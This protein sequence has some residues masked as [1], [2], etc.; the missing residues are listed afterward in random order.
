MYGN[1]IRAFRILR[2][3]SQEYMAE[4]LGINQNTYSRIETNKHKVSV[5]QVETIAKEL[6]V[7][8]V[9]I[10]SNEPLIIQN[11]ASNYGAQG[12][13]EHFY[14]DQKDLYEKLIS[15]KDEEIKNLREI[16][17]SLKEVI[18]SLKK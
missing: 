12:Q 11:I 5:E 16:I 15:S 17:Q 8:I 18:E 2:G 14:A 7:S 4:K 1:K 10:T 3:F 6:G 9:D 13:I